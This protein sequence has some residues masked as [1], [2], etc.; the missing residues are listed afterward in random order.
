VRPNL[1][2]WSTA[3]ACLALLGMVVTPWLALVRA[4]VEAQMGLAQKIMYY[5]VP[6]AFMMYAGF[7]VCFVGSIL[8]LWRREKR[9]DI[10]ASCGAEVGVLFCV[11]VLL[12]G[13]IWARP[14]W[15]TWWAWDPQLTAVMVLFL[16]FVAYLMLKN[17]SEESIQSAKFRAVL[18]IIGFLD[19]PLIHYSVQI[20]RTHHPKVI[21]GEGGGLPPDMREAFLACVLTFACLFGA[22]LLRRVSLEQARDELDYLKAEIRDRKAILGQVTGS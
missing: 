5:H 1:A 14:I 13:P 22:I 16:I 12:S 10:W 20:W 2:P 4:G 3:L 11:L 9:Y 19:V 18:A 8:Y 6:S 7:F 15:N 17:Y 21:R